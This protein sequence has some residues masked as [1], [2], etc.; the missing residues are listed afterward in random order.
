MN[1][2]GNAFRSRW[3]V[4]AAFTMIVALAFLLRVHNLADQ[5]PW[6][7][8]Y[9]S[10][11]IDP[12]MTWAE[13]M[14]VNRFANPDH[15]PIYYTLVYLWSG[16]FDGNIV[17]VRMLS[18]IF[19]MLAMPAVYLLGAAAAGPAA[20]LVAAA[21]YAVS[22]YYIYQA[23]GIRPYGMV[24]FLAALSLY[25]LVRA[26]N[27]ERAPWWIAHLAATLLLVYVHLA[28]VF[29][30]PAQGLYLLI[31]HPDRF[32]RTALWA[33]ILIAGILPV[34][35]WM[36]VPP[37]DP[38][39]ETPDLRAFL[40]NTFAKD[41]T[42]LNVELSANYPEWPFLT[43]GMNDYLR[44][45]RPH[46]G[47]AMAVWHMAATAA[48]TVWLLRARPWRAAPGAEH[49]RRAGGVLALMLLSVLVPVTLLQLV[50]ITIEP[51]PM[52]RYSIYGSI[53]LYAV[54][55]WLVARARPLPPR[56]VLIAALALLYGYQILWI[57]M[58]PTRTQWYDAL[59]VIHAEYVPGDGIVVGSLASQ[60][61]DAPLGARM[62][63]EFNMGE[64]ALPIYH[65]RTLAG[66]LHFAACQ[67]QRGNPG[68]NV[69]PRASS[70]WMLVHHMY[71]N[72]PLPELEDRF[73]DA[74]FEWRRWA[75]PAH[76]GLTLYHVRAGEPPPPPDWRVGDVVAPLAPA[77]DAHGL[78]DAWGLELPP[79]ARDTAAAALR[80]AFNTAPAVDGKH[81]VS[82]A[83]L[84]EQV[85]G[86]DPVLAIALAD[87]ALAIAPDSASAHFARGSALIAAG[88]VDDARAAF[89]R[90]LDAPVDE[91]SA[92]GAD[93]ARAIAEGRDEEARAAARRLLSFGMLLG[94]G[95]LRGL[96]LM[97][98][99]D[100]CGLVFS[101]PGPLLARPA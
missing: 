21:L 83:Y 99:E 57:S 81:P 4:P 79:G 47:W 60:D 33:G 84:S 97:R 64:D 25:T 18:V 88:R 55:G 96:G 71:D 35:W 49:T 98:A 8:E 36:L 23:Q 42:R 61:S 3:F 7:D 59:E 51:M 24:L 93:F 77:F 82:F 34:T 48:L 63:L 29:L 32:R 27:Q 44:G 53:A 62:M 90:F 20:G 28:A 15:V 52:P 73:A 19:A 16:L 85:S 101:D 94:E 9:A 37:Q 10:I 91:R 5:A 58:S 70:V 86:V 17:A 87:R 43:Q 75:F 66:L 54:S 39:F 38:L 92:I 11:V 2:A 14:A 41:S 78:I 56:G 26:A 65:A 72:R 50:S 100:M 45:Q 22:P 30:L 31:F 74:G 6:G 95:M 40:A 68:L 89:Q 12:T 80:A 13:R 67:V 69:L 76:E 1:A 46:M